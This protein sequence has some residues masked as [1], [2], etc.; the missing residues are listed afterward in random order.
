MAVQS[1]PIGTVF[2]RL[3]VLGD[4][5]PSIDKHGWKHG[6]SLVRCD[7][8]VDRIVLNSNLKAGRTKSCGCGIGEQHGKRMSPE[9]TTWYGIKKRCTNKNN[10]KYSSYGGRGITVCDRWSNSFVEFLEDVGLRPTSQHSLD[11]INN[12][13][14]YE[15]G[16]CRWATRSEQGCNKRNNRVFSFYGKVMTLSQWCRI[17][18]IKP[19]TVT[20]RLKRGWTEKKAFWTQAKSKHHCDVD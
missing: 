6:M 20:E 19:D 9:Y 5:D 3:T 11:R 18:Q 4:G 12:D 16:N 2:G 14:N 1:I 17:A 10:H 15:P 7:C 13:G 8:G